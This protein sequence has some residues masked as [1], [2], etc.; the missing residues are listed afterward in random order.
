MMRES[1]IVTPILIEQPN[2]MKLFQVKIP[3]EAENIVGVEM[4][5][6]WLEGPPPVV[7]PPS[8]WTLPMTVS[9]N[10]LLGELKLQSYE[11]SNMFFSGELV[12]NRNLDFADY[13]SR[14][15][16]PK[17]YTHQLH[18]YEVPVKVNGNTTIIQ[19]VF[20]DMLHESQAGSYKYIV[21]VY[22][23]IEAKLDQSFL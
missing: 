21:K 3:R 19:G 4:G 18:Q 6:L 16:S 23:W 15:F 20:R 10:L 5:L 9:R 13:S 12:I 11:K 2:Q 1:V 8:V 14:F 22:T 7:P 17:A